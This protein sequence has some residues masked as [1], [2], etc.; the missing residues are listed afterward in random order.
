MLLL[1]TTDYTAMVVL[2]YCTAVFD[3]CEGGERNVQHRCC[4][5]AVTLYLEMTSHPAHCN[6]VYWYIQQQQ[7]AALLYSVLAA[8]IQQYIHKY[9]RRLV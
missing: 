2:L 7:Q 5:T 9:L 8:G 1:M 3:P 6:P 4:V